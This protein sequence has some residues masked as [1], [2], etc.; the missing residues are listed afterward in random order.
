MSTAKTNPVVLVTGGSAGLGRVI[1]T[2]F[3]SAGYRVAI[4]GRNQERL[5]SAR[6]AIGTTEQTLCCA[7][8]LTIEADAVRT[9]RQVG[10]H[11]GRL[12][13][14]V[15]CVGTSDRGAIEN[16]TSERMIDLV[17]QN[18]CTTLHCSKAALP[19]LEESSGV[20]IN[21]G[22][23]AAKVGTRYLGGYCIAKHALA[24]MTQQM[25]LEW[26]SRGVH[27]G[28]IN[29]G[30]IRRDDEG[31]RYQSKLDGNIPVEASRPG[32]GTKVKGLAADEV[33]AIVLDC[34]RRRRPDVILPRY[35]RLLITLGNLSPRLGDWLLLKFSSSK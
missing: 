30:P 8:D 31:S 26:L 32:G 5:E 2:T 20:I 18:V 33:A 27:V 22:S 29:P 24:G 14:L 28:L 6:S 25:R 17:E 16:L 1:A 15:N 9:I 34:V 35:L 7:A 3:A 13:V 21:I 12:D 10:D 11:F 4:V 23:L 19:L